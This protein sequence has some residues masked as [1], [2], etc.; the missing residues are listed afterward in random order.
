[1]PTLSN[2]APFCD[3]AEVVGVM[4]CLVGWV[5]FPA[6]KPTQPTKEHSIMNRVCSIFSQILQFVP[7]LE[8]E[9]A[10]KEH[11]AERHARGFAS[12]DQFGAMMFCQLG[13]AQSL[14]EITG[15]LAASEGKLKHLGMDGAPKRSTLSY[16]NQH[17]PWQLYETV[18]HKLLGRCQEEAK[19]KKRKFRFKHKLLSID[20]TMVELCLSMFDWAVYKHTK[21]ALKLHLV[22]DHDGHLPSYAVLTDGKES[23]ITVARSMSFQPGTMLVFDRGYADYAWWLSLT[24]K[25]VHFVTR[26][27][28]TASYGVVESRE[29]P[30]DSDILRDEV[31]LLTSQQEMG[32]DALLRRIEVWLEDKQE[33][34]VFVTNNFTLAASTIAAIYKERWQIELFFKA[35]KQ[36]LKI[37]TFVGTSEN[38]VQTQIWTALIAML[39][40]KYLQMRSSFGW[41]LSNLVALLRQQLFVYR[42]LMT[43]LNNPF[44]A[45]PALDG[46]HD[47]QIVLAFVK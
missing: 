45:P 39:L 32:K 14:R 33:T 34:M 5:R 21:G 15:G 6:K 18:F 25:K 10:V 42:D 36:S 2:G 16:A 40:L 24:R 46:I 47:R 30:K 3:T 11:K 31:I 35:I 27:K 29:A 37:K 7:R 17:R 4:E 28:D 12:W 41:S 13:H 9:A 8:F 1:M 44:Q 43:W 23:E 20:G 22:L 26:L 38:A 19:G